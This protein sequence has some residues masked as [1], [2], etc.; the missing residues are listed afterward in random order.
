MVIDSFLIFLLLY[1][2]IAV[3]LFGMK[4]TAQVGF[5]WMLLLYPVFFIGAF[6][7]SF[8]ILVLAWLVLSVINM[9]LQVAYLRTQNVKTIP[10]TVIWASF[11]LWPIQLAA[12]GLNVRDEQRTKKNQR[13]VEKELGELP[14][15]ITGTV[16][17]FHHIDIGS[18]K[19]MVFLE[20]YDDVA[21]YMDS[22]LFDSIGVEEGKV[23][24]LMVEQRNG[25]IVKQRG[26]IFWAINGK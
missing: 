9:P 21:F 17:F 22:A 3:V 19:D 18:G 1:L 10:L 24:S 11:L 15:Q 23:V 14:T 2:L 7:T 16:S 26:D 12:L 20:E 4:S 25:S 13:R 6:F 5:I 8:L